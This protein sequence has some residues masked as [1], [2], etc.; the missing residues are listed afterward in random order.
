VQGMLPEGLPD[1]SSLKAHEEHQVL[2][3]FGSFGPR[4]KE[5]KPS[6]GP[7]S[8]HRLY[9]KDIDFGT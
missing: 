9:M 4:P 5:G 1:P 3:N 6:R 2:Q 8:F 7:K